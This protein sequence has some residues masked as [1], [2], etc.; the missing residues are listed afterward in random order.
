[1]KL[2]LSSIK[3]LA[4]PEGVSE[5]TFF[6][7]DLRGFGVRIRRSG[8]R[9]FVVQYK[10]ADQNRRIV[11]GAV[12]ALSTSAKPDRPPATSWPRSD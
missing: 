5:K 11:L 3:S 10:I 8:S 12:A 1:M 4:L 9:G 7:D 6:D 2:T